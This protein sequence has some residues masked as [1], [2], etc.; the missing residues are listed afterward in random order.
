MILFKKYLDLHLIKIIALAYSIIEFVSIF[1]NVYLKITT[2]HL[3]YMTWKILF[4]NIHFLGWLYTMLF[5]TFI[6]ITTKIMME[7]KTRWIYI[8][9]M[10]L[11][12]S[13]L[14][15]VFIFK[16]AIFT[17]LLTDTIKPYYYGVNFDFST[18]VKNID[19]YF[20]TYLALVSIIYAYYYFNEK[21]ITN[22]QKLQL[23]RQLHLAKILKLKSNLQPHFLFNTLNSIHT[24][25]QTDVKMS[26]NMIVDLSDLL[27]EVIDLKDESMINLKEELRLLDKYLSIQKIRFKDDLQVFIAI[28][29]N[30]EDILVPTMIV[31]PILENT[32]K[33]GYSEHHIELIISVDIFKSKNELVY[34]IK[35]NGKPLQRPFSSLMNKGM[36][37]SN[38]IERLST[39]YGEDNYSFKMHNLNQNVVTEISIPIK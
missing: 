30:L 12:A 24:L 32:I 26:Q 8:I 10:H 19:F 22:F 37:L 33:H 25:M 34:L 1:K 3:S 38:I 6:A 13:S 21:K 31:Q 16:M 35:N 29:D 9:L 23:E 20:V 4:F 17:G 28:E 39:I 11:I 2:D 18:Y 7:K 14:L 15:V 5:M 36:G 27:R